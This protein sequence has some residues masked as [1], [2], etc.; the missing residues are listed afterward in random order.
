MAFIAKFPGR[1]GI[2]DDPVELGDECDYTEDD[3]LA[4]VDCINADGI[5]D[6]R[7]AVCPD[8]WTIHAG[9]CI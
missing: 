9:E 2:C 1:C 8:C 4:H 3:E 7:E 5:D 6:S